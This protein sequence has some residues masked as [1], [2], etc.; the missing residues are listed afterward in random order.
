[1]KSKN[2][3][4][5]KSRYLSKSR[6]NRGNK[7]IGPLILSGFSEGEQLFVFFDFVGK[8]KM[9]KKKNSYCAAA[10]E[11]WPIKLIEAGIS[12]TGNSR[13]FGRPSSLASTGVP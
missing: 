2:K 10:L 12:P 13:F 11:S 1:M 5:N 4:K 7:W 6:A 8:N 3:T 9:E